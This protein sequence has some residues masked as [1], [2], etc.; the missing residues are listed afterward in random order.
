MLSLSLDESQARHAADRCALPVEILLCGRA[1]TLLW[2]YL[3]KSMRIL[4]KK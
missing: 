2:K 3:S 4:S 1:Y